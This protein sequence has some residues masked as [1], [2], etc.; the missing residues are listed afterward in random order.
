MPRAA[1][2]RLLI[3]LAGL[4]GASVAWAASGPVIVGL[5]ADLS[6]EYAQAGDAIRRGMVLAAKEINEAGGVLGRRLIILVRDHAGNH[7]RSAENIKAFA[8]VENLV[9]VMGAPHAP[10]SG[11]ERKDGP[12]PGII[13]LDPWSAGGPHLP[14][15]HDPR[16]TFRLA[17]GA[18]VAGRSLAEFAMARGFRKPGLLIDESA[19]GRSVEKAIVAALASRGLKPAAVH[20]IAPRE[21]DMGQVF[22]A[23]LDAGADAFIVVGGTS[24]GMQIARTMAV[25]RPEERR[26]IIAHWNITGGGLY[27]QAG[28]SLAKIDLTFLQTF[29]FLDPPSPARAARLAQAYCGRFRRCKSARDIFVPMATAH[30]YDLIRMLARAI[31]EAGSAERPRVRAALE[32]IRRHRGLVRDYAAPFS[33]GRHEALGGADL[34]LA[35][36]SR[37]GA[38]VL[39]PRG[40]PSPARNLAERPN[41]KGR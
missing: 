13:Y 33:A 14:E 27:K 4:F 40:R 23:L 32:G 31:E 35:R 8:A 26:P 1:F 10:G 36:Y 17:P 38:I 21:T 7:A 18:V 39:E 11:P 37:D 41:R 20:R 5:D 2:P 19:W 6:R 28:D 30:A 29:S 12:A 25:L 16:F 34:R 15:G 22:G 24:A 9:A 3:M